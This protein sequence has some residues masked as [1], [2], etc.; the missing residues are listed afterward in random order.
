MLFFAMLTFAMKASAQPPTYQL[1]V[2]N[3]TLV[4]PTTYQFDVYLKR[5]GAIAFELANVGFGIG[6]DVSTVSGG[7]LTFSIVSGFSELSTAQT[8]ATVTLGT[9][10]QTQVVNTVTYR[11][12]NVN[13][14]TNP[15]PGSGSIISP[16]GSC[17]ALGTRV[18][19]FQLVNTVP[20]TSNSSFKHVFSTA[21]GAGR[22]NTVVSAYV[23]TTA[24]V[25]TSA[26]SNLGYNV[27]GTC[28]NNIVLNFVCPTIT[29]S[30]ASGPLA[31]GTINSPYA[32]AS[33]SA[34][35]GVSPY[36]F[37]VTGGSLPNGLSLSPSGAITGTPT[38]PAG[39]AS[40]TVTATDASV[41]ACTGTAN[42]TINV[43]NGCDVSGS[44]TTTAISCFGNT[45][46]TATVTLT[47]TGSGAPGTYTVDGGS[48]VAYGSNPFTVSGLSAGSHTIVATVTGTGCV[49]SDITAVVGNTAAL[50]GSATGTPVSCFGSTDGTASVTLSAS[51]SG[52]YT[53][54][55]GSPQT[56]NSNP[57]TVSGLGA[58]NHTIVATSAAGCVS[59]LIGVSIGDVAQLTG[60]GT[61][62][63]TTCGGGANG[64]ATITLSASTSG[65][66]TVDGGGSQSYSSNPFT[67][68]GLSAGPHTIVATSAAGCVSSNIVVT[69][70]GSAALTATYVKTNLAACT[71]I[72]GTISVTP[73]G[74]TGPYLYA[75]S[76]GYPGFAPGNVSSVT[77]LPIGYYNVTVTD[78][79]GC[80]SVTFTN[81]HIE[82]GYFVYVTNS[83][84][85]SSACGNTGSIILYGNA[86]L[87]PY[88]YSLDGI[89]YQS[90]NTFTGLA[91]GSYTAYVKDNGG[92]VSTKSITVAAAPAI[93][94]TPVVVNASTCSNDGS[95]QIFR[96]GG[97]PGYTY[98]ITSAT[99]PWQASNLFTGLAA[100]SYT[101]YVKDAAGCVGQQSVTIAPGAALTPTV[102][103]INTSTCVNDGSIQV[104]AGGGTAPYTY[105]NDGG[106]TFQSS[107]SFTGLG[108]GNYAIV[109]KDF[110]GCTGSTN[111]TISLNTI[112][113]TASAT[114]S[115][116]CSS[117]NGKIQLFRTGGYGPYT[118]S[119][120]GNTY[121]SSNLFTNLPAGTYTGYVK[122]AKTCIGFLPGIVVG[123]TGCEPTFT[124]ST[125]THN[126][127]FNA[128]I[129]NAETKVQAY[130][131]PSNTEF[132]LLLQGYDSKTK[133][134]ITVTDL[135]GRKVYQTE[136]TGKA[137][138]RFGSNFIAGM[139]NVQVIQGTDKKSLKL[140]KE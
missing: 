38:G 101:A 113:V 115:T 7:T 123:P 75:W 130:P 21:P 44:A 29:V 13:A 54:D 83:G 71:A 39:N 56:Y 85:S 2:S 28:L 17:P 81:I 104:N 103:K 72:N 12:M 47:G 61:T 52:T 110:K 121:Q 32:G 16:T 135:L 106:T 117:N 125:T 37:T 82:I 87:T 108:Q 60:S 126:V 35:G 43:V 33:I 94:V 122:D 77:N 14:R 53:V 36:T 137:Q 124:A 64:T 62:T 41:G 105:S 26:A 76:G 112:V 4:N 42:Y 91:A 97:S 51:T 86:G 98:S 5:T 100:G 84:S 102:S 89:T 73:A 127:K 63:P 30:P 68:T 78:L 139:Y 49:S 70:S 132:T 107:N 92:C 22:N 48:P 59:D 66:Y 31:G 95:I 11:Y 67:I 133:V 18:G 140:V 93:V 74:G 20:F 114:A 6:I 88:S 23:G 138:Y 55:G 57:F 34:T 3:E 80:G 8:P 136:G 1:T 46:G 65:T 129:V 131:N 27:A 109:V 24:T 118:Y 119:L 111:V 96:T 90:S 9:A 134:S 40:F 128:S 25:I 19:R 99:G 79:G 116:T 69:V 50:T 58:G 10:A 45:D 120:D 15:G